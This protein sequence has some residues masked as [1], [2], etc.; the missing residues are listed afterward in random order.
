MPLPVITNTMRCSVRGLVPS[1]QQWVN[2]LHVRNPAGP[3]TSTF[4]NAVD[5]VLLRL[6]TGAAYTGGGALLS[7][8]VA[9]VTLVDIVYTP[10]DGTSVSTVV[11]HPVSGTGTG[12]NT[13]PSEVSEVVTFRTATRGRSHRGRNYLPCWNAGSMTTSGT[14]A[15][16]YVTLALAQYAGALSAITALPGELV[17]ASYLLSTATPVTAITMDSRFDVQRGRK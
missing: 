13:L 2:T 7:L 11:S 10:L 5:A 4:L 3:I 16:S 17:V 14:I 6:Y 9:A 15:G 12:S 8:S 1:G